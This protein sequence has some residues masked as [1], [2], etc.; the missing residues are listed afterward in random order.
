M[1]ATVAFALVAVALAMPGLT[2]VV[3]SCATEVR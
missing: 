3:M 1:I 2:M